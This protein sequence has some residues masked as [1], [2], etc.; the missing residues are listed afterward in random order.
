MVLSTGSI[1]EPLSK[2][3]TP[4]QHCHLTKWRVLS[5]TSDCHAPGRKSRSAV[6]VGNRWWKAEHRYSLMPAILERVRENRPTKFSCLTCR[7]VVVSE[8][9]VRRFIASIF[10]IVSQCSWEIEVGQPLQ[11]RSVASSSAAVA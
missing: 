4:E 10:F 2:T 8:R 3:V 9:R 1:L 7:R 5:L 6:T 11:T